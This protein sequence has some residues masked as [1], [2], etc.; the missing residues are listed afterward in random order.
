MQDFIEVS[1]LVTYILKLFFEEMVL[2]D[3]L[4]F[5]CCEEKKPH[6]HSNSYK[7]EKWGLLIGPEA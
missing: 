5:Y 7:G 1:L 6:D 2:I 4:S 3:V